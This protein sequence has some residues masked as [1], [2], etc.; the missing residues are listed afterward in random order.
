MYHDRIH[1][2]EKDNQNLGDLKQHERTQIVQNSHSIAPNVTKHLN[3]LMYHDR[4]P[5]EEKEIQSLSD[6]KQHER[7]HL[8]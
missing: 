5:T 1:T 8:V 7:T 3:N 6:L 4:I 2:E